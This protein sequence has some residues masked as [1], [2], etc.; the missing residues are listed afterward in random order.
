MS[1]LYKRH[2]DNRM[3][4]PDSRGLINQTPTLKQILKTFNTEPETSH[5]NSDSQRKRRNRK[6]NDRD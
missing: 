4:L 1:G 2:E 6:D 5:E 3:C